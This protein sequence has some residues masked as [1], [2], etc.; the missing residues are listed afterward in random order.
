MPLSRRQIL[1]RRRV[2]VFGAL[3]VVL[4]TV[5]YLPMTLLAPLGSVPATITA[6]EPV[7][8]PAAAL[9]WPALGGSAVG[10]IGYDGVLGTGGSDQPA[11]IASITKII[12]ALVVLDAKP[13]AVS[14]T[15]P[16]VAFTAK[17]VAI[18]AAYQSVNGKTEP[19]SAGMVLSQRQVMDVMLLESAN[20]YAES[21]ATWAFGS[22][23]DFLPV[24]NAWLAKNGLTSTSIS[25][26]TGMSPRNVS[27]A[28]DLVALGKLALA[29]PVVNAIVGTPVEQVPVVGEIEN[30]NNLLGVDGIR[31]IKTGTLDEAGA[32]LL[33]AAD[34]PVGGQTVTIVGA[35]LGGT[36][37]KALNV[38]VRTLLADVEDGFR[39]V[40]LAK[41]GESFGSYSTAWGES[42]KL[43]AT[44]DAS[45]V[46]WSDTPI[47]STVSADHV[48]VAAK[49]T[50]VGEVSFTAGDEI[51]TVPLELA[52]TI[53]D[54]GPWWRLTNPA[55]LF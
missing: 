42:S 49:G 34:Y 1:R 25:D 15:G 17:D 33:F 16:D 32:C 3:G 39:E 50:D 18:R 13:L 28:T 20:N 45:V 12:T 10:A 40:T 14:D 11:P 26:P 43:V 36:D 53:D 24:A 29:D 22:V 51:I 52:S 8:Q 30:S 47:D 6:V 54:P 19:V 35:V 4:G 38:T 27:T 37:H 44:K 9:E 5:F 31:G 7:A 2:A 41:A 23:D 46:V 21:L 55:A 48:G